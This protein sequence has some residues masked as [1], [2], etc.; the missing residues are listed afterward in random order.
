[1]KENKSKFKNHIEIDSLISSNIIDVASV[2]LAVSANIG[3]LKKLS[4]TDFTREYE[5]EHY[6][7]KLCD[8]KESLVNK[9]YIDAVLPFS[10]K[11]F[12]IVRKIS[13]YK[14]NDNIYSYEV[15]SIKIKNGVIK[16]GIFVSHMCPYRFNEFKKALDIFNEV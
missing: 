9:K 1:M 8:F 15:L 7:L 12:H 4:E 5:V 16:E 2:V 10:K 6:C 3:L 14:F 13:E 11:D